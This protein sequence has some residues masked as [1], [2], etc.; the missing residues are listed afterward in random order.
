[1]TKKKSMITCM[2]LQAEAWDTQQAGQLTWL[3]VHAVSPALA[4]A[5]HPAAAPNNRWITLSINSTH[6]SKWRRCA[7]T[8]PQEL[9][10]SKC[11]YSTKAPPQAPMRLEKTFCD[12]SL[13]IGSHKR[14]APKVHSTK[15]RTFISRDVIILHLYCGHAIRT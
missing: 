5:C 3:L 11:P 8:I 2:V 6:T 9:Q 1:V 12:Y 10:L 7:N 15:Q 13:H 14:W 4:A